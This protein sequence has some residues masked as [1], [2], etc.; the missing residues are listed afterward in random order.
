M[1]PRVLSLVRRS[2][3]SSALLASL[4]S[5]RQVAQ[6]RSSPG[7]PPSVVES[8]EIGRRIRVE[9]DGRR[10]TGVLASRDATEFALLSG[11]SVSV[12]PFGRVR[13]LWT[14]KSRTWTG[15]LAG[16]AIG[17]VPVALSRGHGLYPQGVLLVLGTTSLGAVIGLA[18]DAWKLVWPQR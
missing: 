15:A 9:V 16:F 10:R 1:T 5:C 2:V 6:R 7:I 3:L 13:A 11:D 18:A 8:V 14:R 17:A 12:V 4:V